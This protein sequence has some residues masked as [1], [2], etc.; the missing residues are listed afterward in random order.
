MINILYVA[1][2]RRMFRRSAAFSMLTFLHHAASL[3]SAW[4]IVIY[5]DRSHDFTRLGIPCEVRPMS[6]LRPPPAVPHFPFWSKLLAY[7]H[8]ARNYDGAVLY[9]DTDTYFLRSPERL[10]HQL[11]ARQSLMHTF[12]WPLDAPQDETFARELADPPIT[13]MAF[14]ASTLRRL[15]TLEGLGMWNAGLVALHESNLSL[16]NEVIEVCHE[17]LQFYYSR[18][19]EQLAWSLVLQT[20]SRVLPADDVVCH[21]WH[22]DRL[23]IEYAIIHFLRDSGGMPLD[24]LASRAAT[25]DPVGSYGSMRPSLELRTRRMVRRARSGVRNARVRLARSARGRTE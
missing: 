1:H 8:C 13:S 2:G 25:L 19:L 3:Q 5:T 16:V 14:E 6:D 23:A 7:E 12:E 24:V 22:A 9:V 11:T 18:T 17:L 10:L 15:N 21:Y 20:N 4:R